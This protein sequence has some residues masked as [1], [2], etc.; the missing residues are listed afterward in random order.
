MDYNDVSTRLKRIYASI[1]RQNKYGGE[2]LSGMRTE[3]V[4]ESETKF[5]I[6]ISFGGDE[7]DPETLNEIH[8]VISNLAN[9]KDCLLE[10]MTEQNKNKQLIEDDIDQS[11]PLQL[12]LD[13]NNQ[14][15]HGS[16]LKKFR[17]SKKDPLFT[18]V[19]RAIGPSN[20][21]DGIA[22]SGSDGSMAL[23]VMVSLH[24]DIT[25]SKGQHLYSLDQLTNQAIIDWESIIAKHQIA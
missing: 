9:L 7:N 13:L 10:K 1:D 25:D 22:Y 20:K 3:M 14:E 6:T 16:P 4:K 8:A 24:A 11:L 18:N 19:Y 15:K 21:P 23:N 5:K 2:V 17:R 12:V